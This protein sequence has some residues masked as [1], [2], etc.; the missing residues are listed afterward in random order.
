[1]HPAQDPRFLS[2]VL[3]SLTHSWPVISSINPG[4]RQNDVSLITQTGFFSFDRKEDMGLKEPC[5][6]MHFQR[7]LFGG[8]LARNT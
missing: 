6:L 2:G 5:Y 4:T 8:A 3:V 7:D 1:M